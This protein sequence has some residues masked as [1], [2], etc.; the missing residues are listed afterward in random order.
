MI[1][2]LLIPIFLII[3]LFSLFAQ[4]N[5]TLPLPREVKQAY[6]N[7]TRLP[8]GLPG[9]NYWQNHA[10]YAIDVR[11]YLGEKL[12]IGEEKV[13][14]F[15]NSPDTLNK[16]I[17]RLYPNIFKKGNAREWSLGEEAAND[18]VLIDWLLIDGDSIDL[19]DKSKAY[20]Y[21][22]NLTIRLPIPLAP[23]D[24]MEMET[25]WQFEIS[26]RT[27]RMGDYGNDKYFI[28]YW[29]P[30]IAVYDDIDGWD[31]VEY[32]G[33]VEYYNDFNEF[34]VK[35]STPPGFVVWATGDLVNERD[36]YT[37]YVLKNLLT[38]RLTDDITRIFSAEDFKT[39]RKIIRYDGTNPFH[40]NIWHFKASHV[41]DFSFAVTKNVNWDGTSLIV[42]TMTGRR[43]FVDA[44]YSDSARTYEKSAEWARASVEYMSF[45][46]PGIPFPYSHMTTISNDRLNGGME[47]PMMANNGDPES[48]PN[49]ALTIFHEIAHSYFPF[50]MGTNE[51][52]YAWMDEG[53]AAFLPFE[54]SKKYFP[55]HPYA[56]R[57]IKGFENM[58]GTER[59]ASTMTLSYS[60]GDYDSY[61]IHAY[62]RPALAYYYLQDAIGKERFRLAL[63][64]Y[65]NIWNGKHPLPYDFFNV[66]TNATGLDLNWF[67][68]PWF[69]EKAYADLG[70]KKVTNDNKIVIQNY[71]GLP[72]PVVVLCE[73][74][75]GTSELIRRN[76]WVWSTEEPAIII[77]I[78][79]NKM[80]KKVVLGSE[81]IPDVNE[82][83]NI[84]E[85]ED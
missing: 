2:F 50:Y 56:E 84:L 37:D 3:S 29:Y 76:T 72:L 13:T 66:F 60:I 75:D 36:V 8:S 52:K 79:S 69:F 77:E 44:V 41:P 45:E 7:G 68:K 78:D 40:T 12:L 6:V 9:P 21:A 62:V 70:I 25:R 14:Y 65:I 20:I 64:E 54:F 17:V 33:M 43:V 39:R 57:S 55:D 71:G 58:N 85:I 1:R 4:Q 49:A 11:L 81:H 28:A 38:A 46:L 35:I 42:D 26:N 24:S 59:E 47:S 32:L 15:N 16:L 31:R 63:Q 53:W 10:K 19:D 51:R 61:R 74:A 83:N 23:G 22:T 48:S 34:D 82:T 73:F 27:L 30:Q 80:L 18:G 5:Q 67:F